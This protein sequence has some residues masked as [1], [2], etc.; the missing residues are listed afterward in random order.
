MI[1]GLKLC[2]LKITPKD[3]GV[4]RFGIADFWDADFG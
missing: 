2:A 3:T 4:K 1:S